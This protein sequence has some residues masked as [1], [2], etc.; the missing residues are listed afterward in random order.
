MERVNMVINTN[1]SAQSSSRLLSESSAMLSKSLA[2]LSSGSKIVSPEDDAAG[3]A[4]STRFDAQINRI[5][6]AGNNVSNAI[7][8]NQTQDGFLKKVSKA[9]DRMSELAIL[10]QDV[11]KTDDDRALY[12]AEYTTLGAYVDDVAT[13]EFNGVALFDGT[14]L[15]VTTDSDGN[16]YTMNAVDLGDA[17]YTDATGGTVATASDA[18]TAL[19]DVKTAIDQLST[20]RANIG[21]NISRLNSTNEG[22]AVLKDNL[23]AAN[24]R[25]K[26]VDVA[27]ES[28][29]FA[30]YNI[31]VQAGTAML[32]QANATPQSAL[33]LLS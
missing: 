12:D 15:D 6:A 27:E 19:T 1:T 5:S 24:S 20:D 3:L 28:T 29:N 2:R 14:T 8:F 17:A 26:D 11:T 4:V 16:T 31:L 13:K 22:L 7:S 18:A 30:R 32:A 25:I 10:S 23:S 21:A 33:R 9:L